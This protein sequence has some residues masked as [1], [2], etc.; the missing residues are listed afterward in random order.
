MQL[1]NMVNQVIK[2]ETEQQQPLRTRSPTIVFIGL[3]HASILTRFLCAIGRNTTSS[4]TSART[5]Y[6]QATVA[7]T[8]LT[9]DS[10]H[11]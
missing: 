7:T 4:I 10:E 6:P 3:D 1:A 11:N 2:L 8:T 9:S 5:A